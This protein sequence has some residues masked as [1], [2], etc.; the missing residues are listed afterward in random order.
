MFELSWRQNMTSH[1]EIHLTNQVKLITS[2]GQTVRDMLSIAMAHVLNEKSV[3]HD[4]ILTESGEFCCV[5]FSHCVTSQISNVS[6][7]HLIIITYLNFVFST[8]E[9]KELVEKITTIATNVGVVQYPSHPTPLIEDI[10]INDDDDDDETRIKVSSD[11]A[12]KMALFPLFDDV[13][14]SQE[15]F[16][17]TELVRLLAQSKC[18]GYVV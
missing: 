3:A 11:D 16:V 8:G 15:L 7:S 5:T 18:T 17:V 9:V 14:S 4:G 12:M 2:E 10:E 1:E 6:R 13:G